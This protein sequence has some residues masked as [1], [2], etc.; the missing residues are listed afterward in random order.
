MNKIS[1]AVT[2]SA[3]KKSIRPRTWMWVR[4][5][6]RGQGRQG[7]AI[8]DGDPWSIG[9]PF[10]GVDDWPVG[11][12]SLSRV[13][14]LT[15]TRQ[16]AGVDW[17]WGNGERLLSLP[18]CYRRLAS[19]TLLIWRLLTRAIV[20]PRPI[21]VLSIPFLRSGFPI[22]Y[23]ENVHDQKDIKKQRDFKESR[24]TL[25][26]DMFRLDGQTAIGTSKADTSALSL[27][28]FFWVEVIRVIWF[29]GTTMAAY[30][31]EG[32]G[33]HTYLDVIAAPTL[34]DWD[35]LLAGQTLG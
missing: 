19:K 28:G 33:N 8:N 29:H 14:E 23:K 16:I 9:D 1:Y 18:S 13:E 6:V 7:S 15:N 5:D 3:M 2:R 11:Q 22:T 12:V 26:T 10:W 35:D 21:L 30:I 34:S 25:V 17:R 27:L 20:F 4:F 31:L 32:G 24:P